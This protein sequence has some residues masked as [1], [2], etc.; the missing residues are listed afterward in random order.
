MNELPKKC[1]YRKLIVNGANPL[2]ENESNFAQ[3]HPTVIEILK[4]KM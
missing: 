2:V 3:R 4:S 1:S